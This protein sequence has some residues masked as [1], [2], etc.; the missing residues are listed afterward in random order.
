MIF[1]LC[2]IQV[3]YQTRIITTAL[4]AKFLLKKALNTKHWTALILLTCGVILAQVVKI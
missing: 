2:H 3:T 1:V 4:F